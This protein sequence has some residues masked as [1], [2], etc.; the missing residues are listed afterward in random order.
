MKDMPCLGL[1]GVS[2]VPSGKPLHI[3]LMT[4]FTDQSGAPRRLSVF[5]SQHQGQSFLSSGK[6]IIS[7]FA[8]QPRLT[9][10]GTHI[11][12]RCEHKDP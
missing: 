5:G 9:T 3:C 11:L 4:V 10:G 2:I 1:C 6:K 8:K 12:R 7:L